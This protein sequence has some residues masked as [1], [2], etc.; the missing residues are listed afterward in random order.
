M[1]KV[2]SVTLRVE[3]NNLVLCIVALDTDG[4][5]I[6]SGETIDISIL[7]LSAVAANERYWDDTNQVFDEASE[8]ALIGLTQV[9]T[10]GKY[11][12]TLVNGYNS[13]YLNYGIHIDA[14]GVINKD[15]PIIVVLSTAAES[16]VST[17]ETTLTTLIN[18]IEGDVIR[19]YLKE[20]LDDVTKVKALINESNTRNLNKEGVDEKDVEQ[21]VFSRK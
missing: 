18:S 16:L 1:E 10:T 13:D 2:G 5:A 7:R 12:Y 15:F 8:P 6:T 11:E 3:G 19:K 21:P 17:L 20:I 4:N 9:G 14:D